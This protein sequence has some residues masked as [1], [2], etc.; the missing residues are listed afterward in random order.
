M[1]LA[2]SLAPDLGLIEADPGQIDQILL[3]LAVN[4]RDAM[5]GGGKLTIETANIELDRSYTNQHPGVEPGQYVQLA[6][7]DSG[8]GFDTETRNRIF[9]PFFTTKTQGSGTGLGL[10]IVYG[11]IKQN[12]GDI[13]V[14]SEPGKGASFKI[15]LPRKQ[16]PTERPGKAKPVQTKATGSETILVV[17]DEAG[18]LKLV[19]NVLREHGYTVLATLSPQEAIRIVENYRG[20]IDLLLTDVVMPQM[21]GPDLAKALTARRPDLKAVYMSGYAETGIVRHGL[22][23]AGVEFIQ[24]PFTAAALTSKIRAALGPS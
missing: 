10:S 9:E 2:I 6:V 20:T 8:V 15:Y 18:V 21:S 5:P 4:A 24:K 23:D 3:N 22:L 7:T 11:I 13:L 14:Y 1:E 19:A 16:A 17:E 12:G